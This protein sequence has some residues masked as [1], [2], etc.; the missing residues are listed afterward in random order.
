MMKIGTI[1]ADFH[2]AKIRKRFGIKRTGNQYPCR[3]VARNV[4]T[5]YLIFFL[6]ISPISS[7]NSLKANL[8]RCSTTGVIW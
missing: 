5:T 7:P 3:D 2:A 1:R 4:S 8:T 6:Q